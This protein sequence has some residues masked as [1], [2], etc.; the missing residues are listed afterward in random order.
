MSIKTVTPE[1]GDTFWIVDG[2]PYDSHEAALK[3]AGEEVGGEGGSAEW[4]LKT[5][6]EDYLSRYPDGPKADLAKRV[7]SQ[8]E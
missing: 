1:N 7:I 2:Q 6:P 4:T 5:S 8:Q 3:A